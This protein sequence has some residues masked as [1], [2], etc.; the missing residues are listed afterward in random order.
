M[1][2]Y[3]VSYDLSSP[4]R[5]YND[6]YE[7]LKSYE[8]WAHIMQSTWC[9]K[10]NYSAAQVRDYLREVIDADDHMIVVAFGNTWASWLN[11]DMNEWLNSHL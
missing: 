2:V 11:N 10:T 8:S 5:N 3:L 7:R 6:L 9:I 4:K 1:T